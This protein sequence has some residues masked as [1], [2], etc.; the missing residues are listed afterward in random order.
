MISIADLDD[1]ELRHLFERGALYSA[2]QLRPHER[3]GGCVLGIYFRKTSTR[4]RTAFAAG[5]L[6]LGA[7]IVMYG[8]N[9]LQE[10]T[11][12]M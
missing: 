7:G 10:N 8:P 4:T 3:L 1:G 5:A 11:G 2:E 6:R 12:L 9:D